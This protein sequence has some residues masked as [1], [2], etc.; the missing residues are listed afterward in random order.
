MTVPGVS[1]QRFLLGHAGY[2][3]HTGYFFSFRTDAGGFAARYG[4]LKSVN[5]NLREAP[6]IAVW[7]SP[8]Y[9]WYLQDS[10]HIQL[11][12]LA[13]GVV[14]LTEEARYSKDARNVRNKELLGSVNGNQV[15]N[16][17]QNG[18]PSLPQIRTDVDRYSRKTGSTQ[19]MNDSPK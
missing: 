2:Q 16:G 14:I 8:K 19:K 1:I 3:L 17:T 5:P 10:F 12:R 18:K 9:H 15:E 4:L 7:K 13:L 11:L 6:E